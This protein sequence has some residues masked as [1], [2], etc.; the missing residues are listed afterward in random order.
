MNSNKLYF[1]VGCT[2]V[3][4]TN[5]SIRLAQSFNLDILSCDSVQVYKNVNIGSAKITYEEMKNVKHYG[6]DICDSH[7][8]FNVGRYVSYAKNIIDTARENDKKILVVGGTGLYLQSFFK[9][10]IDGLQIP[11]NIKCD[12]YKI[13]EN[14]GLCGLQ[15][16]ILSYG[17]IDLNNSDWNN[18]R[19]LINI[20]E[21][22]QLTGLSQIEI[23]KRY[24]NQKSEFDNYKKYVIELYRSDENLLQRAKMRIAKMIDDG[25]IEESKKLL[26]SACAN[27]K[28]AI[29]YRET[30]QY[31]KGE[32]TSIEE[33]TQTIFNNTKNLIKKQKTWFRTQLPID[34]RL[35]LDDM[36]VNESFDLVKIFS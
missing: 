26:N 1:L 23:H 2:A 16:E 32:I 12:V 36:T 14:Y 29:G 31:L 17:D 19:R 34:L 21:K 33:L 13:Y 30:F 24:K 3:G 7:E 11:K 25:L 28:N 22:C 15:Q 10:V 8:S 27:I 9:P 5:M 20:L 6:I 4:K 35:N 18:A